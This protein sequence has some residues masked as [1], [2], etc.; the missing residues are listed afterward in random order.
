MSIERMLRRPV[1]A[2]EP[3]KTCQDAAMLM[4]DQ[5]IGA[6]VVAKCGVPLGIVTDRDLV[7]RVMA[8]EKRADQVALSE[9]MSG[10]PIFLGDARSLDQVIATMR[11]RG[12]RRMPI[13]DENGQIEGFIS[14]D[15]LIVVLAEQIGGLAEV[16]R[17]E[18]EPIP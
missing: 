1:H 6:V 2:L 16:V 17:K 18:L 15:D 4:R 12:I 5:N 11:E 8:P 14:W 3:D 10:E 9:V 7:L 13:V